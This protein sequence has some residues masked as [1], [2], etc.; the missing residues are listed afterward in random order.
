M[1]CRDGV[2]VLMDLTEGRLSAALRRKLAHHVRGCMRCRGFVRS[3]R[4]IS[5]ILREAT[6]PSMPARLARSLR[7]MLAAL[8]AGTPARSS[9]LPR[10]QRIVGHSQSERKGA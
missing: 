9:G 3:Y 4:E 5:R 2:H 7:R 10:I 1:T 6:A 8:P